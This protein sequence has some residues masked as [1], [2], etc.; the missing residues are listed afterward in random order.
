MFV[1]FRLLK[2]TQF[3]K[4]T[5]EPI[6]DIAMKVGFHQISHFGKCFKEKFLSRTCQQW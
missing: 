5:N 2:A 3:L 6:S 4:S 1:L